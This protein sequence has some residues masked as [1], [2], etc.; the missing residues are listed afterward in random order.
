[1]RINTAEKD[2]VLAVVDMKMGL[3]VAEVLRF[4]FVT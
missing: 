4:D 2:R 3:M 1:M